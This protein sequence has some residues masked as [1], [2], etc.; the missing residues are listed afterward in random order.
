MDRNAGRSCSLRGVRFVPWIATELKALLSSD[1]YSVFGAIDGSLWIGSGH[2]LSRWKDGALT[3][4]K[5]SAGRVNAIL[6]DK[7][8]AIW[9]ARTRIE[10]PAGPICKVT[11]DALRCY[12]S[13]DGLSCKYGNSLASDADRSLWVGS[14]EAICRWTPASSRTYLQKEL[15]PTKGVSGVEATAAK[16]SLVW[17]GLARAGKNF[18]LREFCRWSLENL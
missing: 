10:P 12:G 15:K 9:M 14:S 2:G 7:A 4:F 6:E 17:A 11:S 1:I 3:N 13:T 18:G 5:E 16:G 8:G